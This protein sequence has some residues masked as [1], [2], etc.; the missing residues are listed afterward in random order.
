MVHGFLN[1]SVVVAVFFIWCVDTLRCIDKNG[2]LKI[3]SVTSEVCQ[4]FVGKIIK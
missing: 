3:L 4:W 2:P 1:V